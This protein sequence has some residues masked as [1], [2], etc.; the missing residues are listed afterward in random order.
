[1]PMLALISP[2]VGTVNNCEGGLSSLAGALTLPSTRASTFLQN[3]TAV[4]DISPFC[5]FPQCRT[6]TIIEKW[7]IL[8]ALNIMYICVHTITSMYKTTLSTSVTIQ[9][10]LVSLKWRTKRRRYRPAVPAI[11][12]G[13]VWSLG[14]KTDKLTT[15]IKTQRDYRE[16]SVLCFMETWLHIPH[17]SGGQGRDKQWKEERRRDCTVCEWEVV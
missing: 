12:M 7:L 6:N 9:L 5:C 4:Y 13:N 17:C 16:C 14:N 8:A 1:M 15:L 10:L 3:Y 2:A 11:I